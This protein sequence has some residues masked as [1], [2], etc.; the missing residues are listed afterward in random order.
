M[1]TIEE[2]T[3]ALAGPGTP[4][5]STVTAAPEG[6]DVAMPFNCSGERHHQD[7]HEQ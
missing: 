5:S 6:I 7:R 1:L 4:A 3:P 2:R